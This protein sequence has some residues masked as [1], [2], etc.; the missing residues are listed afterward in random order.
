MSLSMRVTTRFVGLSRRSERD[1]VLQARSYP[2]P[3]APP[4]GFRRRFQIRTRAVLGRP[5]LTLTP[6]SGATGEQLVYTHGGLYVHPLGER[7]WWLIDRINRDTGVTVTVPLYRLAPE[8]SVVEAYQL[9]E[10]VYRDLADRFGGHRITLAGDSAGGGLALGQAIRF[11]DAGLPSPR[12]VLLLAPWLD[13]EMTDPAA[14][15]IE[16]RDPLLTVAELVETGRLWRG[17]VDPRD[18]RVSPLFADLN[19]LPPVHTWIGGRD[20]LAPDATTLAGR[21]TDAGNDGELHLVPQGFHTFMAAF[22]TPEA[23]AV[24]AMINGRLRG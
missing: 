10:A 17:D 12:Q 24:L 6:R 16:A 23:R 11:R 14:R 19:G 2:C 21:L 3:A 5:V 7:H 1:E 15:T 18:P 9:L 8:G 22:W 4:R 20:V 13:V